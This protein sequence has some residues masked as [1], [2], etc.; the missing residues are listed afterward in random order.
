MLQGQ[1]YIS[2]SDKKIE[3]LLKSLFLLH[4]VN[5]DL[6]LKRIKSLLYKMN[7]PH[8]KLN[9]VVQIAG[10]NGK[11]SIATM[12]YYL[13]KQNGKTINIY[14][15]PHLI[16]FNERIHILNKQISNKYLMELLDY[17][18]S[19]ND[20]EPITFFEIITATALLA[21]SLDKADITI[22]EVGLGGRLDATNVLNKNLVSIISSIGLDHTEFLG[23]NL[24][25]IA[26]EK[27][28]IIKVKGKVILSKQVPSVNRVIKEKTKNMGAKLYLFGDHWN[29]DE[30]NFYYKSN[31]INIENLALQG[32]HQYINLSCVIFA[33]MKIKQ[34]N[35]NNWFIEK[36]LDKIRWPGRIQLLDGSYYKRYD[37]L[38][39]WV[40]V[41]HNV[42][43][44]EALANWIFKNK[45][46]RPKIILALGIKKDYVKILREIKKIN[47]NEVIFLES[48]NFNSHVPKNLEKEASKL[49]I[50]TH[51][52]DTVFNALSYIQ[53]GHNKKKIKQT[54]ITGSIALVGSVL[55][56]NR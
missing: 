36:N 25:S 37:N 30:K 43:G 31:K 26:I 29:I 20:N 3:E 8:L 34:L 5:V 1:K 17:V 22:L 35:L 16:T 51:I 15:S 24:T 11:G 40:D 55:S 4:P 18:K 32:F 44:F 28:G 10:T 49:K 33:C 7:N 46:N 2:H 27:A 47:P 9:N 53:K 12:L 13:Q 48:T 45:I 38:E 23:K 50:K 52:T 56:R 54:I 39:I 42:L 21:F 14:R 6:S 41:A 19:I